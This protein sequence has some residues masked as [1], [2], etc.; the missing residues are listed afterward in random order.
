MK[1]VLMLA[2]FLLVGCSNPW[3]HDLSITVTHPPAEGV[4]VDRSYII[5]W[6]LS[7]PDY[8]NTG[9]L[10][11]VDTDLNPETGLIQI[12]DT[13]SVESSGYLWDCTLFPEDDYYV[14]VMLFEGSNSAHDYSEGTVRVI[15]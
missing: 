1:T 3:G 12:S 11:F 4:Q 13:L 6:T 2:V 14:R 8:S 15:H 5:K 9:I 10:I 7:A